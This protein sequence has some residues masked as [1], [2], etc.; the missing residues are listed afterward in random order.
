MN[1][2]VILMVRQ[3]K[4]LLQV[5]LCWTMVALNLPLDVVIQ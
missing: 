5:F 1:D 3:F 2:I 4:S